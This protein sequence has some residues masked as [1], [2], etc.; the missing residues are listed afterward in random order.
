MFLTTSSLC[1]KNEH[2]L[3]V[4]D[5]RPC[6]LENQGAVQRYSSIIQ[7]PATLLVVL[8]MVPNWQFSSGSGLEPNWNRC[9]GFYPIKQPNRTEPMVFWAVPHFRKLRSLAQIKYLSC[10]PITIWYIYKR[11]SFRCSFTSHSPICDPIT[12]H[13]VASNITWFSVLFHSD[14][15]NCDWI[16][17]WWM[18]GERASKTASFTY[19]LY[20]DTIST[21]ILN[22]SQSTELVKM[23]LC[24]IFNPAKKPWVYVRSGYQPRQDR[25]VR[26]FGPV[27][28]RT[29]PFTQYKP[30]LLAGYP[31]PLLT[32]LTRHNPCNK[33]VSMSQ[34]ECQWS[35]ND[36]WSC[37]LDNLTATERR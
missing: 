1:S 32:L 28:N 23:R 10:D 16:S 26:F 13:W 22:W 19:I 20:C 8:A 14:S 25:A 27:W 21:W 4:K 37:I 15:T 31:D 12:I 9:N 24:S 5:F 33:F 29:E 2:Q 35:V 3:N 30:R 18:G 11:C 7:L 36:F 17:T 6:I 34:N